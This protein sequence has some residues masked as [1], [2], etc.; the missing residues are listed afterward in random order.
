MLD[1]TR[2]T[3]LHLHLCQGKAERSFPMDMMSDGKITDSEFNRFKAQLLTDRVPLPTLSLLQRKS[4]DLRALDAKTLTPAEIDALIRK[5]TEGKLD[6][7]TLLARRGDLNKKREY[8]LAKGDEEE[9]ERIEKEL[10]EIEDNASSRPVGR[11]ESQMERMAR[12]NAKNRK[13]NMEEIKRAEIEEKHAARRGAAAGG[14]PANPFMRV[15]TVVKFRHDMTGKKEEEAKKDVDPE[16]KQAEGV[17]L[18]PTQVVPV[19][20]RRGGVDDV[21]A[22]MDIDIEI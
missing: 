18:L 22:S 7:V 21:I 17:G 15:K 3:D 2:R 9:V 5:R 1:G 16:K 4:R 8:A 11:Q 6:P 13:K 19:K 10:Q 14:D 20:G 12:I